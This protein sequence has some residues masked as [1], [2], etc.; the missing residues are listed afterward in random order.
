MKKI[1]IAICLLGV[2]AG[3]AKADAFGDSASA[4]VGAGADTVTYVKRIL[5]PVPAGSLGVLDSAIIKMSCNYDA[6]GDKQ[7]AVVYLSSSGRP[8]NRVAVSTDYATTLAEGNNIQTFT[9][10]FAQETFAGGT[11]SLW[12]GGFIQGIGAV[13]R[14]PL[15]RWGQTDSVTAYAMYGV[16]WYWNRGYY[17]TDLSARTSPPGSLFDWGTYGTPDNQ[18]H[19]LP[20][21]KIFYHVAGAHTPSIRLIPPVPTTGQMSF[22]ATEGGAD[23][24]AQSLI[25]ADSGSGTGIMAWTLTQD[26]SWLTVTPMSGSVYD[27]VSASISISGMAAGTYKDTIVVTCAE[28]DNTPES[29]AVVLTINAVDVPI[30]S[31]DPDSLGF[32]GTFGG[33]NPAAQT[34]DIS[35]VGSGTMIWGIACDSTWLLPTADIDSTG[36]GD[37]EV[38]WHVVIGSHPVGVY[39]DTLWITYS[40]ASNSPYPVAVTMNVAAPGRRLMIR[41]NP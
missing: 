13:G 20:W 19:N 1:L 23:P 39:T 33:S 5:N 35:N 36:T 32:S 14:A 22:T 17:T 34:F 11:D 9:V 6:G 29:I 37:D 25:I 38:S 24:V 26:S 31:T 30:I 4:L 41:K 28:A 18:A 21:I 10:H 40:T 12:I 3:Q 8:G 27:T 7:W 15:A 16:G 2:M